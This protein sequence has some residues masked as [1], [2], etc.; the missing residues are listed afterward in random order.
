M[1]KLIDQIDTK[2]L[3]AHIAIIMDGNRRWA[4]KKKIPQVE[5]HRRGVDTLRKIV[6]ISGDIGLKHLTVYG[7]ST[8]NWR[9]SS[10]EVRYLLRLIMD[11]LLKEIQDLNKNDVLIRFLGTKE[12]LEEW[13][14]K[15]VLETCQKT[16]MNKGL[17]LNIAMNYGG[18]M[19]II[20]AFKAII[21][22]IQENKYSLD[23]ISED[24]IH[25][26]LYTHMMPDPDLIIR[27]SGEKRLSNFLVWQSAYSEFW[28]T[29]TFWP[30]FSEDEFLQAIYDYQNRDRRLGS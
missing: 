29:D 16:W 14:S 25:Q 6:K 27:T 8:E 26:Y 24:L 20:D 7:F 18:R 28:F 21:N 3:P 10:K 5:G 13:Y 11:S 23:Q 30:E 22:D 15:K 12:K 17:Q 9:R 2:K 1:I 4:K 19:E